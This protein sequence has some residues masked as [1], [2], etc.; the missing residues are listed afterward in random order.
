MGA[1]V[2]E[3]CHVAHM[4]AGHAASSGDAYDFDGTQVEVKVATATSFLVPIN[5][6]VVTDEN[7][8]AF[9]ASKDFI[10]AMYIDSAANDS[11]GVK[12]ALTGATYYYK[13]T[14]DEVA[15]TNVTGYSNAST[16]SMTRLLMKIEVW[17]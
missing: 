16:T 3:G 8:Y 12:T 17:G 1:T 11:M 13:V 7:V 10:V 9:D 15:T 5:G 6:T 2:T 4:Y 14:A